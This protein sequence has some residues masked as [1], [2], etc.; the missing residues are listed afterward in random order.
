MIQSLGPDEARQIGLTD[1]SIQKCMKKM[2]DSDR[3]KYVF[4]RWNDPECLA[5]PNAPLLDRQ[6]KEEVKISILE[7][8]FEKKGTSKKQPPIRRETQSAG[9][10]KQVKDKWTAEKLKGELRSANPQIK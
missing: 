4:K 9:D 3:A 2:T 5:D 10:Y 8:I 6:L 7:N 1:N